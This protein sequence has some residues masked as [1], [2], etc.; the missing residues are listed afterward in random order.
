[1]STVRMLAPKQAAAEKL[2]AEDAA[3]LAELERQRRLSLQFHFR[4]K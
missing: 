3:K 1:M 4:G 2:L